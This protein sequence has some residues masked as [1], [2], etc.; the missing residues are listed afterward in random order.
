MALLSNG[1]KYYILVILIAGLSAC[2]YLPYKQKNKSGPIAKVGSHI[3]YESDVSGLADGSKTPQD[4]SMII[5]GYVQ[6]WV[7]KMIVL[8]EAE[9]SLESSI[10]IDQLMEDYRASLI[11]HNYREIQIAE[12][13]DSTVSNE[14]LEEKYSEV[15][16]NFLLSEDLLHCSISQVKSETKGLSTFYRKWLR[17]DRRYLHNFCDSVAVYCQID[18]IWMTKTEL[19]NYVPKEK[20]E[21]VNFKSSSSYQKPYKGSEYFVKVNE[22]A[23]KGSTPPLSYI[24]SKIKDIIIQ[25]RKRSLIEEVEANLYAKGMSSNKIELFGSD[26]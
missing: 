12:K 4:S 25:E 6:Q 11:L 13:L 5:N 16:D 2:D 1:C 19:Y 10:D 26:Q 23:K 20:Y 15:K 22:Y 8:E 9:K 21:E 24:E 3:L 7:K 14:E 17:N 18:T